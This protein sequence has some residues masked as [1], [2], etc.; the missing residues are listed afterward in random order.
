MA[1]PAFA[2]NTFSN[3]T[4]TLAGECDYGALDTFTGPT[5]LQAIWN[6][7]DYTL[8]YIA[9]AP[10]TT[11]TGQTNTVNGMPTTLQQT[12]TYDDPYS[13]ASDPTLTGYSFGG[14]LASDALSDPAPAGNIYSGGY[15]I[16]HYKGV[17][18]QTMT[19]QWTANQYDVTYAD[20]A[21]TVTDTHTD[22]ATYDS[23]YV[24]LGIANTTITVP[25]GYTFIGWS[26][27]VNPTVTRGAANGTTP[28]NTGTVSNAWTGETP[29]RIANDNKTVYAA[30]L[31]N[32]YNITYSCTGGEPANN[33][34]N[35]TGTATGT[36][37]ATQL[38]TF[39]SPYTLAA[40]T[41]TLQGYVFNGWDCPSL[42]GTTQNTDGYFT[43]GAQGD[44][45]YAGS[46][47]C[48]AKW[49][50]DTITDIQ[51]DLDGGTA[52]AAGDTS[53]TYDGSITLPTNP[54]K[55]G[56]TFGGWEVVGHNP[57]PSGN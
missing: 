27:V 8:E 42:V 46:V 41:C 5:Q 19:A 36:A 40:N 20:S 55:T 21:G 23:N 16:D 18:A 30:F 29:W 51:W 49:K 38:V 34:G 24:A 37:P 48:T 43:E 53:C 33:T 2:A 39:D 3:T 35:N 15:S 13:V 31:A 6:A 28:V 47:T 9:N 57:S 54:Q 17:G 50:A 52:S 44:Y 1:C 32:Q 10:T 7:E 45:A 56:Y 25:T 11:A 26:S 22:D 4:G 12:L 14:W